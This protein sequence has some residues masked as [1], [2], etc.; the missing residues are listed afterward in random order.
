MGRGGE[1]S[2][3]LKVRRRRGGGPPRSATLEEG[4]NRHTRKI[5]KFSIDTPGTHEHAH[6][7]QAEAELGLE[8]PLE[9][10][11]YQGCQNAEIITSAIE[12]LIRIATNSHD[13]GKRHFGHDF[14]DRM[15]FIKYILEIYDSWRTIEALH[16]TII[17]RIAQ[18][19]Y[20]TGRKTGLTYDAIRKE[21]DYDED[22]IDELSHKLGIETITKNTDGWFVDRNTKE[23][24]DSKSLPGIYHRTIAE[25]PI[26]FV[27]SDDVK[28]PY[29]CIK[30]SSD[31]RLPSGSNGVEDFALPY[32]YSSQ[33]LGIIHDRVTIACAL[34]KK[35]TQEARRL[36]GEGMTVK[37]YF[38]RITMGEIY[39]AMNKD[40]SIN[41]K[42]IAN[43]LTPAVM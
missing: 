38:S 8:R 21:C 39:A 18:V 26:Y 10:Y 4:S 13:D 12:G 42:F 7:I 37:P 14:L 29:I 31:Q 27:S 16:Q 32:Q 9:D 43:P 40:I 30:N 24:K 36:A 11:D 17:W 6:L 5:W 34:L 19:R 25:T 33:E 2:D 35:Y 23:V 3:G 1:I 22:K 41:S 28:N 20:Q 15:D